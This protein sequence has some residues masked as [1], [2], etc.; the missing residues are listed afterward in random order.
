[1]SNPFCDKNL[2]YCLSLSLSFH[3]GNFVPE[4]FGR[5]RWWLWEIGV[6]ATWGGLI[7]YQVVSLID[8]FTDGV[9]FSLACR[10]IWIDNLVR[11]WVYFRYATKSQ[12][13]VRILRHKFGFSAA[14]LGFCWLC[15]AV[16]HYLHWIAFGC[17][18]DR[19]KKCFQY[20]SICTQKCK[21]TTLFC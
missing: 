10:A 12:R 13:V 3:H 7:D 16:Q 2:K 5:N 6:A 14:W 9:F 15:L 11:C 20:L 1:M 17:S 19:T 21:R 18:S 4:G 8:S